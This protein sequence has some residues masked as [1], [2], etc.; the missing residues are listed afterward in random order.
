MRTDAWSADACQPRI[1]AA[2]GHNSTAA[3]QVRRAPVADKP[4]DALGN[5]ALMPSDAISGDDDVAAI[6]D[7]G[8]KTVAVA[9]ADVD[10]GAPPT[11]VAI[12]ADDVGCDGV[13]VCCA[14]DRQQRSAQ[15]PCLRVASCLLRRQ[16]PL[17]R[18]AP[19][20]R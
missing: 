16:R 1:A 13:A 10:K 18:L 11:L 5:A 20:A 3:T 17:K 8:G 14:S 2:S 19:N 12:D 15:R 9:E 7:D 6:G 4:I